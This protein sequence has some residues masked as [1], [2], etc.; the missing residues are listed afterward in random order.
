MLWMEIS[1]FSVKLYTA[2]LIAAT[3]FTGVLNG[4]CTAQKVVEVTKLNP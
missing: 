3:V 1:A 4:R 2:F